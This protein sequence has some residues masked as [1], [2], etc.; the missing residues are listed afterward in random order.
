MN[1]DV[2][3]I[4]KET[5]RDKKLRGFYSTFAGDILGTGTHH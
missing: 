3:K 5:P 1:K 4:L 2:L